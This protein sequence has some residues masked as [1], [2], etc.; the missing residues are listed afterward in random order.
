M[1]FVILFVPHQNRS[2]APLTMKS[3]NN[4]SSIAS[5]GI[6]LFHLGLIYL[7]YEKITDTRKPAA[8]TEMQ[9]PRP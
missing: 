4:K 1:A 9:Q 3:K 8:Q 6:L 5:I 2:A 7:V